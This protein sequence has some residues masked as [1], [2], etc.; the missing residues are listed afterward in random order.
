MTHTGH[1]AC[2]GAM[3]VCPISSGNVWSALV[4]ETRIRDLGVGGTA[5]SDLVTV[6][7]PHTDTGVW[8]QD[9]V[10]ETQCLSQVS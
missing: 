5:Q 4:D 2:T 9:A 6:A 1:I 8:T 3:S 7:I 10:V